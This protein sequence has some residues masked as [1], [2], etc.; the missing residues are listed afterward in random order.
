M[1]DVDAILMMSPS[2][3]SFM[4]GTTR[5]VMSTIPN[6]FVSNIRFMAATSIDPISAL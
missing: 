2:L 5:F 3:R 6:T 4:S 1:P